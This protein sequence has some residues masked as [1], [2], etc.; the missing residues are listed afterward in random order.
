VCARLTTY[1]T[2]NVSDAVSE[3][4]PVWVKVL[5]TTED[6]TGKKISLSMK[7]VDQRSGQ[8]L[9]RWC[10]LLSARASEAS[11]TGDALQDPNHVGASQDSIRTKRAPKDNKGMTMEDIIFNAVCTRYCAVGDS[12]YVLDG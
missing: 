9:V 1:K 11:S 7:Y 6:D 4:D 5:S 12:D 10:I 3:N 8:D 2:E